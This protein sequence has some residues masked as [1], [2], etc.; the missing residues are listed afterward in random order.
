MLDSLEAVE[1]MAMEDREDEL[2]YGVL[3]GACRPGAWS[4]ERSDPMP[5]PMPMP[6][7][8]TLTPP[9]CMA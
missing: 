9:L 6:G 8:D 2:A 4:G 5:M 1:A 3:G 7:G